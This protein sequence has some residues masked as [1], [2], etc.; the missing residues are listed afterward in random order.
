MPRCP[1]RSAADRFGDLSRFFPVDP[2]G[3][4]VPRHT[5]LHGDP[6]PRPVYRSAHRPASCASAQAS[7]GRAVPRRVGEPGVVVSVAMLTAGSDPAGYYLAR[8]ANCP[9]DYYL[10]AEPIG[11]WLGSGA[12]AAGLTGRLD[13]AGATTLRGL[14]EGAAPDGRQLVAPVLRADPR[15]RLPAGPL[16][17]AVHARADTGRA[18]RVAAHRADRSGPVR[19]PRRR[20]ARPGKRGR[21]ATVDPARAGQL[22]VA[23]GLDVAAVYGTD[24]YAEA[25]KFAGRRVDHR[26]PGIDVTVSAPKSVSV[27]FGLGDPDTALQVRAAHQAAVA[28]VV[29]FLESVAG[30]GLRGHQGDGQRAQ[31]IAHGRLDRRRVRAPDLAGGRPAAAHPPGG[32]E[33]A[34]RRGWQVVRGGREGDLPARP[35]RVLPLPRGAPRAA[36]PAPR[37]GLDLPGQGRRGDR[38]H[39]GRPA[40]RVLHPPPADPHRHGGGRHRRAGRGAGGLSCHPPRQDPRR[41]RGDAAGPVGSEGAAAGHGHRR[42]VGKV[43]GKRRPPPLPPLDQ[44][45]G[46]LLGPAG[47]TAQATGFDRRDLLQAICQALP[48]APSSTGPHSRRWRTGCW[49]AATWSG[50]SPRRR[51]G[52][53]GPPPSCSASSRPPSAWPAT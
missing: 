8:Q 16:V 47:L 27:L 53:G 50:S 15:G 10:G 13:A 22:A 29:G 21:A 19:R 43:L 28:E 23:A 31:R 6:R 52:R 51:T 5:G 4:Q 35:D 32:A 14:L 25:M 7:V 30:H 37:A 17:D 46:Y 49:K 44:L 1:S 20:V 11:R 3:W 34:A 38:R 33:P 41:P 12:A 48:P 2:R 39:P 26:R 42:L 9:A 36:H 24:T 45:A 18:G 40:G